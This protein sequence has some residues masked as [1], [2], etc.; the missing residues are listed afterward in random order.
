MPSDQ[1]DSTVSPH[2]FV[3]AV[4]L[5]R[6]SME[7]VEELAA[8][9][10]DHAHPLDDEE[11]V[12]QV[13][14]PARIKATPQQTKEVYAAIER[15][16]RGAIE[17]PDPPDSDSKDAASEAALAR[18]GEVMNPLVKGVSDSLRGITTDPRD[19][20]Q[21]LN[22]YTK[23]QVRVARLAVLNASLLTS[24]VSNFE[25]L[26]SNLIKGFLRARPQA[27]TSAD[28]K[29]SLAEVAAYEKL[30][31]FLDFARDRYVEGVLRG[32]F[33]DWMSWFDKQLK[34]RLQ[35]LSQNEGQLREIFQRR[36]LFVHNGGRVNRLYLGKLADVVDLPALDSQ[37]TVDSEYLVRALDALSSAGVILAALII[38]K[39]F[40]AERNEHPADTMAS[41]AVLESLLNGRWSVAA[42]VTA[43]LRDGCV[44]DD[45]RYVMRVNGWLAHKRV[46]G[47]E[48]IR[49][50]VESWQVAA[51][52]PRFQLARLALLDRTEEADEFA[53]SLLRQG[54]LSQD[55]WDTWPL[56]AEVR[57]FSQRQSVES[58]GADSIRRASDG[59]GEAPGSN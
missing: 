33:D 47:V 57:E 27:L 14:L 35:Q 40:P 4:D 24:A 46:D 42:T 41:Q 10:R 11:R 44:A 26:V 36:H 53:R 48:A 23:S 29:Y 15:L 7:A 5:F 50:E 3:R 43:A 13:S 39:L 55:A 17:A 49:S 12:I 25:V 56:L 8:F 16:L 28:S 45:T 6:A 22:A 51:L 59:E 52:A 20:G 2:S 32:S 37:L 1:G 19:F 18:F 30:E 38:R 54:D 21:F 58:D 34:I 9:A 31:E